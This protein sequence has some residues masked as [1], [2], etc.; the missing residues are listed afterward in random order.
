MKR[1]TT[2]FTLAAFV[3][4]MA[5][6]TS[7]AQA[8]GRRP[9]PV[10]P[11]TRP[12][13]QAA[14][15]V[16]IGVPG[17]AASTEQNILPKPEPP[18][19]GKIAR[20]AK[21]S[22][23]DFPKGVK[24]P[25]GAPNVILIMTD[26]VGFGASSTFG[27]P[28]QT[29]TMDK[30]A[31]A[32][33][34]FNQFHTTSLCS[35]TR[36]ALIT[37]RNHHTCATGNIM[38]LGTGFPG[39]NTLKSR[40]VGT[41]GQMLQGNGYSTAWFGKNHNVPDWHGSP[42]G[43]FEYWPTGLGFDYF[44]GFILAENNQWNTAIFENT[45]PYVTADQLGPN[46]KHFD[47]LMADKAI[48]WLRTHYS[49]SPN[50]PFFMYYTTGT[51]HSPHHAPKEWLAKYR[52]KFDMGWDKIRGETFARQKQLGVI[53]ENAKLTPRPE[54]IKA[55]DTL[56]TMEKETFPRFMEAY[57]GALSHADH[58]IGRV[59]DT[60]EELGQM[61]NTVVIYIM[62][63]NGASAEG[64]MQGMSNETGCIA[65]GVPETIEFLHSIREDLGGPLYFNH[66]PVGWAHA[67]D[68]PFQWAKQ[69]ASHFGGT[70]NGMV[71]YYPKKIQA[72]G[73]V[74]SQFAHVTDIVPTILEL[75][76]V[77]MPDSIDG[78]KQKPLEG[79][80][81][82]Y[83]FNDAKAP[84]HHPTQYFEMM[85][86]RG[87]YHN[88]WMACTTPLRFPWDNYGNDPDPDDFK[89]ELYN[90]T[91]DFT[92][93][94]NLAASNPAKLK[95]LQQV[96]DTEAKKY[97]VYPLNSQMAELVDPAIRPSLLRGV[98]DLTFYPGT[99]RIPEGSAPDTKNKSF[100]LTA[101]IE[102]GDKPVEGVLATFGGR[103]GGW[104][105]LVMDGKPMFAYAF[106]N[107]AQHKY[108]VKS[109]EALTPGKHEVKFEFAYDG[110][111][112]GK[113]GTGT[114]FI[115]GR[116]VGEGRI[117][118]TCRARYGGSETF[119]IGEDHATPV[120]EDYLD[121]MPFKFTGK[122]EKIK[123]HLDESKL[124]EDDHKELRKHEA[125]HAKGTQ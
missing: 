59:L 61:D 101:E 27:G 42:A 109:T 6:I 73:E 5:V 44:F 34:R 25:E 91:E 84:T 66:Y 30:L 3:M 46:P 7:A 92:Q 82:V 98:S 9:T 102:V 125:A 19:E 14:T 107:Q 58:E 39:Y 26:D 51:A 104:A 70:R 93:S 1:L 41:V 71:I 83:A 68:T 76:G 88:G 67:M 85:A 17:T 49:V 23:P 87:I 123:L 95:E 56:N 90:I 74:R 105:F 40:S 65:N 62:G 124:T 53:P 4:A 80:S 69:V 113:G 15:P 38:E 11:V 86:N 99:I 112:I 45:M 35:P 122:L 100:S 77:A 32:G 55:W 96:F 8:Q 114:L 21:D 2:F 50:Q 108:V 81:L 29:P 10:R 64:S 22:V 116:K 106:S 94:N 120:I 118:Q 54:Q 36:A 13:V 33:L 89:W 47:E 60:I 20:T 78:V 12:A 115:D 18:F 16:Q 37:G 63:D 72:K 110:G 121:R 43:P 97:Q 52:G 111:G 28:I 117:E 103:F 57:A 24:A 75:T 79:S 31:N 48:Q 119:D